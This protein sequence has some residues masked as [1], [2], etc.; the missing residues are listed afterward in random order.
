ML[1][2]NSG[3]LGPGTTTNPAVE[4]TPANNKTMA[5]IKLRS[6]KAAFENNCLMPRRSL[7]KQSSL[8]FKMRWPYVI[9]FAL[10][11]YHD[12]HLKRL[13]LIGACAGAALLHHGGSLLNTMVP[14]AANMPPTPCAIEI[15]APGTC[16]GATPRSCRMLSCIAYIPYMPECM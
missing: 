5:T 2:V 14:A 13:R 7:V 9:A 10:Q 3:W 12:S 1:T 6:R 15:F 4:V 8:A 11:S 16:A